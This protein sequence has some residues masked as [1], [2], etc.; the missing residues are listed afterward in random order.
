[1]GK[2]TFVIEPM[3]WLPKLHQ[4]RGAAPAEEVIPK[5]QRWVAKGSTVYTDG[6]RAYV[7]IKNMGYK[8]DH[9][10]HSAG[11][12]VKETGQH[13][14]H[15]QSVDGLWGRLKAFLRGKHGVHRRKIPGYIV[16][17]EWRHRH[18]TSAKFHTL[19]ATLKAANWL[20]FDEETRAGHTKREA[21]DDDSDREWDVEALEWER[22]TE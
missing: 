11:Q 22:A 10:K 20:A 12:W 1:M 15:T 5:L 18:R 8:H 3:K 4:M 7:R 9:V 6:L 21:K 19:M 2:R 16:E 17:Y 14:V 13:S